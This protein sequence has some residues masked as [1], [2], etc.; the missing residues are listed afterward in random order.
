M[1]TTRTMAL[2]VLEEAGKKPTSGAGGASVA[3][4]SSMRTVTVTAEPSVTC[5][6]RLPVSSATVKVSS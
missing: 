2:K 6:G 4:S 1:L 5:A 3:A